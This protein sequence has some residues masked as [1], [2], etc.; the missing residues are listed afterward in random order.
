MAKSKDRLIIG[1]Q[2]GTLGSAFKEIGGLIA[3]WIHAKHTYWDYAAILLFG[4][5]AESPGEYAFAVVIQFVFSAIL[6][7]GYS[8]TERFIPTEYPIAKGGIFGG[9]I[10]LVIQ[11]VIVLFK[12]Q[13]LQDHSLRGSIAEFITAIVFGIIIGWW[14]DRKTR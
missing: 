3:L 6:A 4:R 1:L 13:Q 14:V 7:A 11:A 10:W 5:R 8:Y 12:I 9:G 2:A